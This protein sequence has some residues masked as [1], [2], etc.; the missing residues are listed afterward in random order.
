MITRRRRRTA[1]AGANCVHGADWADF[2]ERGERG[3]QRQRFTLVCQAKGHSKGPPEACSIA[4]QLFRSVTS[5]GQLSLRVDPWP[6]SWGGAVEPPPCVSQFNCKS[7]LLFARNVLGVVLFSMYWFGPCFYVF[8]VSCIHVFF[9][10]NLEPPKC[11]CLKIM[12][13][14][15]HG[16]ITAGG[17]TPFS[18]TPLEIRWLNICPAK[19]PWHIFSQKSLS[20]PWIFFWSHWFP[21]VFQR[22]S[23]MF[24]DLIVPF[25]FL[26]CHPY[27]IDAMSMDPH[28]DL[29]GQRLFSNPVVGVPWKNHPVVPWLP[30]KKIH[31]HVSW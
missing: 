2:V 15:I 26:D 13:P 27:F 6:G 22:C 12:Y 8:S 14:E 11:V 25:L 31:D 24:C 9:A 16:L 3:S 5:S 30:E 23:F 28:W 4:L 7:I 21:I 1:T 18:D 19:S 29:L 20:I 17:D 10:S